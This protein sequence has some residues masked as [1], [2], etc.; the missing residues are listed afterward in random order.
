MSVRLHEYHMNYE[1]ARLFAQDISK[2]GS[3]LGLDTMRALMAALGNVQ[4][5]LPVIHITG[6]NGKGSVGAY[7]E[8]I[9]AQAGWKVARYCSPAVFEPLE[10]FRY[11]GENISEEEYADMMSQVRTA[12]DI[13][14]SDGGAMPTVFEAETAAA[15]IWFYQKK[16]DVVLLEV[17]M[18]GKTD[19]T[20]VI[21]QPLA[22]VITSISMDHMKFLGNSLSE[23]AQVKAGIIKKGCPVFAAPQKEEAMQAIA[24]TCDARGAKLTTVREEGL[25][26]QSLR[27]GELHVRY[28]SDESWE[29]VTSLAGA[30]QS[31][32][33]A[34]AVEVANYV[35]R[36]L[37][38]ADEAKIREC[39]TEGIARAKWLGRFEVLGTQP[40]FIIDGAHNEGAACELARTLECCFEQG[41]LTM[42]IGVLADKEHEKM[43]QIM[44]PYAKR[45]FTITPDNPRALDGQAL[46]EEAG[47]L[48]ADVRYCSTIEEAVKR[49]LQYEE[50]VLAFGSLS[51][52]AEV[53]EAYAKS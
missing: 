25:T 43:L 50:P 31:K 11:D 20:N 41:A 38:Q 12:C 30:Y 32:N 35:L 2:T 1:E 19:A 40:Y 42:I 10:V 48:H 52:L 26:I 4:N 47:R 9:F 13:V 8:A 36:K 21:E 45:V 22:S 27:P 15:F 5:H 28:E 6:T 33:M 17:G 3:I 34:L 23:I 24:K 16:P 44:L 14:T 49:A 37:Q 53:R 39:I 51:Y 18:G 7:L 29:L 46:A